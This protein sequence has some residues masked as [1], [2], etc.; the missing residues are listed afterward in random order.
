MEHK[1]MDQKHNDYKKVCG[2]LCVQ[3]PKQFACESLKSSNH[4]CCLP[5]TIIYNQVSSCV[6]Q[7]MISLLWLLIMLG[8]HARAT[9]RAQCYLQP[10]CIWILKLGWFHG[11]QI[12]PCTMLGFGYIARACIWDLL[13]CFGYIAHARIWDLLVSLP[14]LFTM[15]TWFK[16]VIERWK[17]NVKECSYRCAI[18]QTFISRFYIYDTYENLKEHCWV[19]GLAIPGRSDQNK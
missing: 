12:E 2:L 7:V 8:T 11:P 3:N 6:C 16:H 1:P 13:G 4:F 18:V 14:S 15:K 5:L 9:D 19:F 10:F 17:L